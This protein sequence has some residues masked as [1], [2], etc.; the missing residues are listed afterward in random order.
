MQSYQDFELLIVD[1]GS[2]DDS[3]KI[4]NT[5]ANK[6]SRIYCY[7]HETNQGLPA[8]RNTGI[9]A[10]QGKLIFFGEDDVILHPHCIEVLVKTFNKL[11]GKYNV[12]AVGPRLILK[13]NKIINKNNSIVEINKLTG[14]LY[15]NW[16]SNIS[17]VTEVPTL[18]ACSLI[19]K[20]VF[21]KVG[22]YD[23]KLYRGN[24]FREETDIYYRTRRAGFYL[25]FQPKAKAY[26]LQSLTGGCKMSLVV[27]KYYHA[28]N[29]MLFL[30]R[31]YGLRIFYL[32]PFFVIW[33]V[34]FA[35]YGLVKMLSRE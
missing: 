27:G 24:Y 1:D 4:A 2:K 19:S 17:K 30:T 33:L 31:F 10:S 5:Y 25:F 8:A 22:G 13:G 29:H 12:G 34:I 18:H 20:D 23:S 15:T 35:S 9:K 26:H 16:A 7:K 14:D 6:D 3:F 32:I 28:R 11:Q 21:N